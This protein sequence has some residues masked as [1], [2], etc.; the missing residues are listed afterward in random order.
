V[1]TQPGSYSVRITDANG[2]SALSNGFPVT[3]QDL[4]E[5]GGVEI[6]PNPA[7]RSLVIGLTPQPPLQRRGGAGATIE[8]YNVLGESVFSP[9][10]WRGVGGEADVSTLPDGVYF[11]KIVAGGQTVNKKFV[12][13]H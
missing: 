6:Y 10:L 7:N 13:L 3:V 8:V 5:G 9:L 1:S 12:V 4:S 2:C 11:L